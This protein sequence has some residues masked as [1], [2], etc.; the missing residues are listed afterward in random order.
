MPGTGPSSPRTDEVRSDYMTGAN[1][2]SAPVARAHSRR[3][4]LVTRG[5]LQRLLILFVVLAA[6]CAWMWFVMVRMPGESYSGPKPSLNSEQVALAAELRRDVEVIGA[7][8]GGRSIFYPKRLAESAAYI[9]DQLV[10]A[11][12]DAPREVFVE[13]G[14][15][16]PNLEVTVTGASLANEIVVVGAHYDSFQGT[17]GADDNASG[18]A[19]CL[20]L[21]RRMKHSAQPRTVRFVFFVNEEP[22][23][24]QTDDMGSL[25]YARE[26]RSKNE[27]IVA[28]L[29]LETLGYFSDAPGSQKYP[30]PFGVVYPST[31]NFVAFVGDFGSREIVRDCV[32][33]FRDGT[34]VASEGGA[35]P[36]FIPGVDWSDHWSFWQCGYPAVMVTDTAP[37]RN[38]NYHRET[39]TPDTLDYER[40]AVAVEGLRR[41]V[42]H[43]AAR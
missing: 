26:C 19:A 2:G 3:L 39:D 18:V 11:G 30:P 41:V 29:S 14:A 34:P 28:M 27:N 10:A 9:R 32:R 43:L 24:F 21:A 12:Y 22:P 1:N 15:P 31:G 5:S 6:A 4:R 8:I 7:E 25:V 33:V 20:A 23:T 35:L 36:S 40:M 13:R 37:F 17:P 38:P 16:T 42:E